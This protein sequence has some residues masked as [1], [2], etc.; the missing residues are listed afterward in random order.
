[1]MSDSRIPHSSLDGEDFDIITWARNNKHVCKEPYKNLQ[2]T[3][4]KVNPC[5]QFRP[6][7]PGYSL[8]QINDLK[9]SIESGTLPSGCDQCVSVEDD[10]AI[11]ERMRSLV[12]MDKNAILEFLH[13]PEDSI[14]Q[15]DLMV[16]LS[17]RCN[18]ACRSCH[19]GNSN[20][21][22]KIWDNK[23]YNNKLFVSESNLNVVYESIKTTYDK[24]G[25]KLRVIVT[26]GETFIQPD[27]TDLCNWIINAGISNDIHLSINTNGTVDDLDLISKLCAN[28]KK[29]NLIISVDSVYDNYYYVR[30]PYTW[31]KIEKNLNTFS[32]YTR[33]F[34]NLNIN[35]ATVFS[36]NNICYIPDLISYFSSFKQGVEERP[37]DM[38]NF[39]LSRPT[40][41]DAK[42]IPQY[43]KNSIVPD[44]RPTLLNPLISVN[45]KWV[46]TSIDNLLTTM[47]N[48]TDNS[49]QL[50]V[51][52]TYLSTTARWD[53]LTKAEFSI[54]NKKFYDL[55]NDE[56]IGIYNSFREKFN[57]ELR[58]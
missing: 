57:K 32:G 54:H 9:V 55:L 49:R 29:V 35:I 33:E 21:Y 46:G 1:M 18:M 36:I 15:F 47:E 28:F 25:S 12:G 22:A 27:L 34:Q 41:L 14:Q 4:E 3:Y 20:L 37:V 13:N 30:W 52:H 11:S 26:G 38:S 10:G 39:P 44:V 58:Q 31:D 42:Y 56:D 23:K 8:D 16:Q 45:H 7:T 48:T 2:F 24:Y 43:I 17:N 50:Q 6:A 40:Y 51:W 5:C 19:A 53:T